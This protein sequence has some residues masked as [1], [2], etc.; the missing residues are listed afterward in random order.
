MPSSSNGARVAPFHEQILKVALLPSARTAEEWAVLGTR[1]G[2]LW[3]PDARQLLPL[4]SHALVDACVDDPAVARL[5]QTARLA[6]ASN[7]VKFER[8]DA[9]L[10]VLDSAGIRSMALKG[11]PLALKHYP[12]PSLRPMTDVDLLVDPEN[13][14]DAV[15]V[16]Q[17]AGWTLEWT[18][19][20][21]FVS[22][23]YEVPCRSRDGLGLLDL[24][25]RLVPWVARSW[26]GRDLALWQDAEALPITDHVTSAPATHD[27]L[28]HVILHAYLS[29][30]AHVPR[31]VADVVVLLRSSTGALDWERFVDRVLRAHLALPVADALTYVASTFEAPV[32]RS[33][34]DRLAATRTTRRERSKHRRGEGELVSPRH[35]FLGELGELR[36]SWARISVNYSRLGALSSM[37]PFLRGRTH[38]EH[39]WTLPFV[40]ARR[41]LQRSRRPAGAER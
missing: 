17:H 40:V 39:V 2:D 12:D 20:P 22:R 9:A 33:V 24:H 41:R 11:V 30:W 10:E 13:A 25:W 16:L 37:G 15:G 19:V 36:T 4:L 31:W 6:W 21:D 14:A 28:L 3:A 5:M 27:L 8:L 26:S 18:I 38:V 35:W 7:H 29:G 32:P 23:T 34:H 1:P